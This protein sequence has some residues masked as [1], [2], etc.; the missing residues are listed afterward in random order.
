[1]RTRSWEEGLGPRGNDHHPCLPFTPKENEQE[2]RERGS[3]RYL[4]GRK[5]RL[6]PSLT[7][8]HSH[9]DEY[10]PFSHR[11]DI[12]PL[13]R[14]T[15]THTNR[16]TNTLICTQRTYTNSHIHTHVHTHTNT[17]RHTYVYTDTY[18]FTCVLAHTYT[19]HPKCASTKEAAG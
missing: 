15:P 11:V 16:H 14:S 7:A 12:C 9:D 2:Q 19:L 17:L 5:R 10:R 1:M 6:F 13:E 3:S 18:I 4:S 8:T